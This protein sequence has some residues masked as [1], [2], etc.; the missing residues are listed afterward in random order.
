MSFKHVATDVDDVSVEKVHKIFT[1]YVKHIMACLIVL[2]H[3]HATCSEEFWDIIFTE[4]SCSN[5]EA[6]ATSERSV[7]VIGADDGITNNVMVSS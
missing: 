7:D 2:M 4:E 1:A 5:F 3:L 6:S